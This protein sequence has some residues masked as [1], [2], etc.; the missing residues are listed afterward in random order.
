MDF[1]C[2][3]AGRRQGPKAS[4]ERV[5]TRSPSD[6][7]S[8]A[9]RAPKAAHEITAVANFIDDH[10]PAVPFWAKHLNVTGASFGLQVRKSE[11]VALGRGV[12]IHKLHERENYCNC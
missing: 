11:L 2:G 6:P 8:T 10:G 5:V 3:G 12:R 9:R 7:A 1:Y 4:L